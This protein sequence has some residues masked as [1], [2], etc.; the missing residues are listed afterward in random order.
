MANP[1]LS[2]LQDFF[3][4]GTL[5][6][7]TW[8]NSSGSPD[9]TLDT[10]LDRVKVACTAAY[11]AFGGNGPWDATGSALYARITPPPVGNGTTQFIM[12]IVVD[13]NNRA[14]L[15]VDGGG[16][17]TATVVNAG[18]ST[19]TVI[20][21]YNPYSHA[22]WR[23][24]EASGNIVFDTAPDGCTWT[25]QATIA[26]TFATTAVQVIWICGYYGTEAAGMAGYVDHVNTRDSSPDQINLNWPLIE[27]AWAPFWNANGGTFPIDRFVDV[28]DRTRGSISV[29]RGRQY[30]TDQVRSGEASLRLANP[31]AAL[32]PVNASGPWA[33]HIQ[34][35]QPYRRRAQWPPTRNLLDQVAATGGDLGG[36][37]LGTINTGVTGPDIFTTTDSTGGSFVSSATAWSGSTVMQFAVPS[38]SAIGARPFH[39]PR[40]SVKPGQTYSV[41]V[42]VRDVTASTSLSVQAAIGW[43]TIGTS[44]PSS[45]TYGTA[46]V[47]TGAT[48]AG[49]TEL[50]VTGT[51][52]ANAAGIDIGVALSA[53]AAA[54]ANLQVDGCQL[55]K[56]TPTT[57][58]CPG[59]WFN[60][61]AG[62]TE[63]WPS[64]W[65]LDG[66][67]GVVDPT[68]VDT[69]ALLS[70]QELP[71]PL[72]AEMNSR[73]PRFVYKLD[74]P[75]GS[76]AVADWTGNYPAAQ[77][78]ISKYGAGSLTFGGS[79]TATDATNGVYAGSSGTVATLNNSNP[80][81]L[82]ISGGA[83]F[84]RLTTAGIRGPADP[85]SWVRMLAFR[86]TGPTPTAGGGAACLWS[87]MDGQRANGSPSGSHIYLLIDSSGSPILHLQGPTGAFN[88]WAP[89]GG[90]N[91][92]DG[93]WHLLLFGFNAANGQVMFSQDGEAAAFYGNGLASYTPTGLIADNLGGFV[94]ATVGN[95]TVWNFKGDIAFAAEFPW[96]FL[97]S[98]NIH[99]MYAAWKSACAGE[100]TDARY[101]RILR[102]A[103]YAGASAVD[104]GMTTA[105]G[106]ATTDGQDAMSALQEVVD[107]ENG[108]HFVDASGK[109]TFKARSARYNATTPAYT[110]GERVDLGEYP[111]EDCQLDYDSTH[112]S[113]QVTVTQAGTSQA[114]YATD[115]T[116]L[117]NYFARTMQRTINAQSDDECQDAASY[118]LSR[119][120]QPAQRVTSLK[121]HPSAN[122]ALWAVCLSLELGTRVRVMRRPPG[123]PAIQV[124]CYVENMQWS[125]DDGGEAW[126]ELQCSPA[127]LTPYGVVAAWHTALAASTV[128]GVTSLTLN[129]PQTNLVYSSTFATAGTWRVVP[130][131][132]DTGPITVGSD[133]GTTAAKATTFTIMEDATAIPYD[134]TKT[135]RVSATIR[136]ATAPTT[137]TAAVYVGLTG[138]DANG[139]RININGQNAVS[140]QAYAAA[141]G[142]VVGSTYT[143]YTGYVSGTVTPGDGG[144]N[145]DSTNPM[146][147]RPEIVAVRPIVYLLYNCTDGVQWMDSFTIHTVPANGG[148]PLAQQ[149]APGQQLTLGQGTANAETVTV[150]AVGA[151]SAGWMTG[152]VTLTAATTKTHTAGDVVCEPLPSG[153]TDPARWDPVAAFD[154]IAFA[155]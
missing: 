68:A 22:W 141:R 92:V 27:D 58:V 24:R 26:H 104:T 41:T 61:Y 128:A 23:L 84:I 71:D 5:N 52:P 131:G 127:D 134:P 125:F 95:G 2:M 19:T 51:A 108:T 106:P 54:T 103:G 47:L 59:V 36:F 133:A 64:T 151:T 119:Y 25:T 11:P 132:V 112:L 45:Y 98:D 29:Q 48:T 93:N 110:F 140:S 126:L 15:Y 116:S 74:D 46:S 53:A 66:L 8:N 120:R 35:Y 69:F 17:L 105:M 121:L 81:T 88:Q 20:G 122:P 32:D 62:W 147:L 146:R 114:F 73:T 34:P 9:V 72:T 89:G 139:N 142:S 148:I 124:D 99:N 40:F 123:V 67:Y 42:H 65:D 13:A 12:R 101:K 102:Y 3:A 30:E 152:T 18:V 31:D 33:G 10:T 75:Q 43:Y 87:S 76:T 130:N 6:P 111:Y 49:W 137:G 28:S 37:P 113:N 79:I 129:A 56:G 149:L 16:V 70:Q 57:W 135:Y 80:G 90:T 144:P 109:I 85:A 39:T 117:A 44:A 94:D 50:T 96:T 136:T 155:Y 77:L 97:S 91:V 83:T 100:S 4:A 63:R 82:L 1:K 150:L 38:G 118:L 86:Y 60:V 138:I 107:T 153:T 55:E 143:T 21:P 14:S 145:N 7:V 154:S 115:D 78:G